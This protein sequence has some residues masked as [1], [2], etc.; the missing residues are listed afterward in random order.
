MADSILRLRVESQEY[1]TKLKRASQQLLQLEQTAR[2]AGESMNKSG[3]GATA[4]VQSLGKME[5]AS[6]SASGRLREM[7]TA[8]VELSAQYNR[9]TA[10]EKNG[11]YGQALSQSLEQLRTRIHAAQDEMNSIN[12]SMASTNDTGKQTGGVLDDLAGKFGMN[13]SQMT[14]MGVALGA[15]TAACKVAKD[16][17]MASEATVDEWGRTVAAAES[18]YNS[19]LIALN[20]GDIGGFLSR[21]DQIVAAARQAYNELDRLDTMRTIQTPQ[22][23]A[24]QTENDRMR[25]MI[26][27]GRYIAPIDGRAPSPG[28]RNGQMLTADQIRTLEKQLEQGTTKVVGLVS[29]EIT[30]SGRAIDAVYNKMAVE[31]GMSSQE[32]RQGTSSMA[33]FDRRIADYEKYEAFERA[34]TKK[35]RKKSDYLGGGF[36]DRTERDNAVNPYAYAKAWGVFKDD[37]DEYKGLVS[38]IQQRDQQ[39]ANAYGIIGQSYQAVNRAEGTTVRSIMGGGGGGAR[40]IGGG[41]GGRRGGGTAAPPAGSIAAQEALVQSLTKQWQFATTDEDRAGL[42]AKLK[43]AQQVLADMKGT[44][45]EIVPEGSLKAL[46]AELQELNKQR[47]LLTDP[48]SIS[49]KDEEI[50]AVQDKIDTLNGKAAEPVQQPL[51]LADQVRLSV[52]EGNRQTDVDTLKNLLEFQIKNGLDSINIPAEEI[53]Q[54]IFGE[55]IN[56]SDEYWANLETEINE[57]LQSMGIEPIKIE[58]DTG[59]VVQAAKT[60]S[61]SWQDAARSVG[62]LGQALGQLEDPS[63][64]IAGIIGQA[65]A[66][67]ALGFAQATAKSTGGG[68]WGW[69][70]AIAGGL[71]TMISTIATIKS[72]TAGSYAEGGLV[73]G[74]FNS[75]DPLIANVNSGELILNR[76]QQNVIASQLAGGSMGRLELTATVTGD[77]LRFALNNN[78]RRRGKGEYV[79]SK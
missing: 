13:V 69:I 41:G 25:M 6:K 10:D 51:S 45:K 17:F 42:L 48:I 63:A 32:F 76:S 19:F 16:A 1:D 34:H 79:T 11:T 33:E 67:I 40:R 78:S 49:L 66:N 18:V 3:A 70:A 65:I 21:I 58:A 5:T 29:N 39:L 15:A 75:G 43:E 4:F 47:E 27:T 62:S 53:E 61:A 55:G 73:P 38:L 77:Q 52:A 31:L 68:V 36:S 74:N 24:Q 12:R 28:M 2:N 8:F 14:K 60:T 71:G 7:K 56:I 64:K 72:A 26:R 35:V 59:K 46:N 22:M 50:A 20:T 54:M 9:L 30:Q 57:K 37:G 44:A 23:S